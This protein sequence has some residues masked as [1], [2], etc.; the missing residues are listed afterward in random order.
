MFIESGNFLKLRDAS[1]TYNF[2]RPLLK[3]IGISNA[4][5][6]LQGRNLLMLTANS[7]K[8]DPEAYELGATDPAN[9][10]LGFTPWRPMPEMYLGLR[11][12]F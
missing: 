11:V 4:S 12:N 3:K 8:L 10:E 6:M 1:I 5:I 7:D 2:N 9:A